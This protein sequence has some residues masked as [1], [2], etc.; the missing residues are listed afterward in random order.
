MYRIP[1]NLTAVLDS[2]WVAIA[3]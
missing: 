2:S 3:A 1:H